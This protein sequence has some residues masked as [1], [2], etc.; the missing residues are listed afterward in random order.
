[1]NPSQPATRPVARVIRTL[2]R[3][4]DAVY[5][6]VVV[7]VVIVLAAAAMQPWLPPSHLLRDSQVVA[8]AHGSP[9]AAYGLVSNLGILVMALT[10]GAALLGW[11][12]LR[13]TP[14]TMR[15]LLGWAGLLTLALVL[16]DLLLLHETFTFATWTRVLFGAA[17]A[18]AFAWFLLRFRATIRERLDI[19]LLALS[20][21]ALGAS[22][23]VDAVLEPT[24]FS[25]LV[26]DGA[27]LLGFAAWSAFVVRAAL[28][29]LGSRADA[30]GYLAPDSSS[31]AGVPVSEPGPATAK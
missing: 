14:G 31:P 29:A 10:S 26:E 27:K 19:G 13:A 30:A 3:T 16:D 15:P 2:A 20:G 17:Y 9:H 12:V 24:Q 23:L 8:I 21:V 22:L 25:V 1:V 28:L 11:T 18:G 4:P 6:A 5:A 7:P